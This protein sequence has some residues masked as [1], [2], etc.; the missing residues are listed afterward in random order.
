[1]HDAATAEKGREVVWT[2][3]RH[4]VTLVDTGET[5]N[6]RVIDRA[7]REAEST[8]RAEIGDSPELRV[9]SHLLR[10]ALL[11]QDYGQHMTIR[12]YPHLVQLTQGR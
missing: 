10:E 8:I 2:R 4:G 7:I 6:D 1:M 3:H 9:A 11:S 5:L 12:A